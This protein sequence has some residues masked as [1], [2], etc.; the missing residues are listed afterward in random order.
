MITTGKLGDEVL[1]FGNP[2]LSLTSW[3]TYWAHSPEKDFFGLADYWFKKI[4][5]M[6]RKPLLT[7]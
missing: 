5:K 3:R 7:N 4:M 1:I 6:I 2:N